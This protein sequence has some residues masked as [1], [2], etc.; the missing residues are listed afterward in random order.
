MKAAPFDYARPHT[1]TEALNLLASAGEDERRILAGGQ[2]LVPM[3]AMRLARPKMLI[4]INRIDE[5]QGISLEAGSVAIRACTR[6]RA[7]ERSDLVHGRLPLLARAI[8][9]V[10]HQQ[11]RNRG[12]VG[13][14]IAN[15]D[16]AAEIPLVAVTL[17]AEMRVRSS[18]AARSIA[19]SDFFITEM[20]T[21]MGSEE[22][23]VEA[24]FPV[25][26]DDRTGCSFEEVAI[27]AG[28]FAI[29]AAA[30]QVALAP[31]GTCRR[32]ALGIGGA[33]PAPLRCGEVEGALIGT[34]LDPR[35]VAETCATIAELVEPETDVHA[36]ADYR[37]RVA[38]R[39]AARAIAAAM[40]DANARQAA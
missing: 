39:I 36:T 25:W 5:L 3:L 4:D 29:V 14:S 23:L 16:P 30:V 7:A 28:D 18:S 2:T 34:N 6:Q 20:T 1:L 33:S 21:A 11:T 24:R 38:P 8:A 32:I 37:R 13:G 26:K 12:T 15:A 35:L 22:C 9:C 17:D 27:R 19:S 31:D 10:G 40:N